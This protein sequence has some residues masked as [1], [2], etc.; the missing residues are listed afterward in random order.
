MQVSTAKADHEP[1]NERAGKDNI[2]PVLAE[3]M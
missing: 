1:A 2:T 3:V